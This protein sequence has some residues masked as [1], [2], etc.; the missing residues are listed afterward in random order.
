[1]RQCTRLI[2]FLKKR[3][4]PTEFNSRK[5]FF[6]RTVLLHLPST[7]L[8]LSIKHAVI[9][10]TTICQI[11]WKKHEWGSSI[12]TSHKVTD[13]LV[14]H[15]RST[16][17]SRQTSM[18]DSNRLWFSLYVPFFFFF[19]FTPFYRKSQ[20]KEVW[21][22]LQKERPCLQYLWRFTELHLFTRLLKRKSERW[23]RYWN[24]YIKCHCNYGLFPK[25]AYLQLKSF[26]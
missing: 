8:S 13:N 23:I 7:P 16:T 1:M 25:N 15:W 4:S 2:R 17:V 18:S 24:C 26:A 14:I 3:K 5:F 10:C 12:I 21:E 11:G 6:L 20:L 22:E 19:T 9:K